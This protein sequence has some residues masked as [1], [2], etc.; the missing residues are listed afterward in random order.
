MMNKMTKES[1]LLSNVADR[2]VRLSPKG[3][4]STETY[5]GQIVIPLDAAFFPSSTIPHMAPLSPHPTQFVIGDP[6][7]V[8][9]NHVTQFAQHDKP[10]GYWSSSQVEVGVS[11]IDQDLLTSSFLD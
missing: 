7:N 4:V 8:L 3:S 6:A 10:S 9:N 5:K 1:R 2:R 11:W